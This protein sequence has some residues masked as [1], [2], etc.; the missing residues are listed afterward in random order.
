ME[1]IKNVGTVDYAMTVPNQ[2]QGYE[3]Y[4]SMPMVYES[5]DVEKRNAS[6]NMLGYTALGIIALAGLGYGATRGKKISGLKQ[7]KDNLLAK[8]NELTKQLE[9]ANNKITELTTKKKGKFSFKKLLPWNWFKK[10]KKA[11]ETNPEVK[12]ETPK[13]ETPK[14][15]DSETT[16][17]AS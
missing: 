2:A 9:E 4:S 5:N 10:G 6:S 8:N 12:P 7:E 13:G 3:D 1:P 16:K 14:K 17:P 15:P 11:P